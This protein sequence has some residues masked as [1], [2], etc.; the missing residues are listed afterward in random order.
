MGKLIYINYRELNIC[1]YVIYL[2][3]YKEIC[4][5]FIVLERII[6]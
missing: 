5:S 2:G 1:I 3:F 6:I 4:V